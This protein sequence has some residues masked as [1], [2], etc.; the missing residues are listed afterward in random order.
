MVV[1]LLNLSTLVVGLIKWTTL[2]VDLLR[3]STFVVLIRGWGVIL[4]QRNRIFNAKF[5]QK[6]LCFLLIKWLILVIYNLIM[7]TH[8]LNCVIILLK[9]KYYTHYFQYLYL[10]T[11]CNIQTMLSFKKTWFLKIHE[12]NISKLEILMTHAVLFCMFLFTWLFAC[13]WKYIKFWTDVRYVFLI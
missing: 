2:I 12:W 13:V 11:H 6:E 4:H 7:S 1:T 8:S 5:L 10:N 3:W 9:V